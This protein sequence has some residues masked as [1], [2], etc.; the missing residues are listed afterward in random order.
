MLLRQLFITIPKR[1]GK[2]DKRPVN[3]LPSA[4]SN[5]VIEI[6]ALANTTVISSRRGILITALNHYVNT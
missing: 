2:I 6:S 4:S 3:Q 5:D 1:L